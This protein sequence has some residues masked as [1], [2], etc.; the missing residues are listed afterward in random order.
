MG[1]EYNYVWVKGGAIFPN[2]EYVDSE[3]T[4]AST[5]AFEFYDSNNF[6]IRSDLR[7][8][9]GWVTSYYGS[10]STKPAKINL[11]NRGSGTVTIKSGTVG[12]YQ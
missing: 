4:S 12:Y 11:V 6:F 10:F 3:L 8:G 7:Y 9:P 5:M 1:R 2:I